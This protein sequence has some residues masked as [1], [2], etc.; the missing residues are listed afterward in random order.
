[1]EE[2]SPDLASQ[3][4]ERAR[5]RFEAS[6]LNRHD[7]PAAVEQDLDEL[8]VAVGL[9]LDLYDGSYAGQAGAPESAS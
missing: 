8:D 7:D 3:R 1:V 9:W 4:V 2:H 6:W 5:R